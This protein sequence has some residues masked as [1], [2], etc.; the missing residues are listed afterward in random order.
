LK[1]F[2]PADGPG[3]F[4]ILDGAEHGRVFQ[5]FLHGG[6]QDLLPFFKDFGD[7]IFEQ[8]LQAAFFN[9]SH[10][11]KLNTRARQVKRG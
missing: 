3:F 6:A 4:A 8:R 2:V 9:R 5:A 7:G 11:G 1:N 10:A